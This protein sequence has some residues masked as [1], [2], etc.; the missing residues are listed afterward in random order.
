[1]DDVTP[2]E[3]LLE[4]IAADVSGHAAALDGLATIGDSIAEA[5]DVLIASARAGGTLLVCGNGGSAA[6]AQ[7]IVA[8]YVGRF[9]QE[10]DPLP[11]I[12]LTT[13][14][15]A[16]TAIANDYGFEQA[17]ARQVRAYARPGDVVL[18]L[19]T[20]GD[21]ENVRLAMASGRQRGAKT[22][23]LVGPRGGSITGVA[24]VAVLAPG[25]STPR[26]Q[27]MHILIG[28]IWCGLVEEY[29]CMRP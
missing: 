22:I 27:E 16:L 8:E 1:M 6:D 21:S 18:G 2:R 26:I 24:D 12:A 9:L 4:R 10:R 29:A 13:N 7:H 17:F 28:H 15:S 11:A 25:T 14:T 5:A 23:A 20:S 19:S 3:Q